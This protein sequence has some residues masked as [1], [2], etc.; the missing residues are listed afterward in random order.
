[1]IAQQPLRLNVISVLTRKSDAGGDA[2]HRHGDEVIHVG[3]RG[4]GQLQCTM[5]YV[6]Q[7]LLSVE[8]EISYG[9]IFID[10]YKFGDR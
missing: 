6:V 2:S 5:A 4:P 3:I 1:M 9:G 10:W 8:S 7:C